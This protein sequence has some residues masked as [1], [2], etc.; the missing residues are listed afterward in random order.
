MS[1]SIKINMA[2]SDDTTFD[3]PG[4]ISES[5]LTLDEVDGATNDQGYVYCIAEYDGDRLTGNFKVGTTTNPKK[6]LRDL[7]TG[8]EH[9]LEYWDQP[10]LV[11]NRLTVEK[12][13]HKALSMYSEHLGGGTEWFKASTKSEQQDFYNRFCRA[14]A[15]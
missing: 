2:Q 1:L 13:A 12:R 8:N 5:Q 6:R 10:Q 15:S 9:R 4:P 14:I 7:Q 3:L 11:S